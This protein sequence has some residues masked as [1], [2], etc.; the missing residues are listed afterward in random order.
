MLVDRKLYLVY[1][2][3][4]ILSGFL[5][6]VI[7][8]RVNHPAPSRTRQLSTVAPMVLRLKAWESRSSPN[9]VNYS[10]AV[11]L[12]DDAKNPAGMLAFSGRLILVGFPLSNCGKCFRFIDQLAS[13]ATSDL[14]MAILGKRGHGP[15]FDI[16]REQHRGIVLTFW[17]IQNAKFRG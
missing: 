3:W 2:P 13:T 15:S 8:A 10:Y 9:L 17:S 4:N 6:L 5:G 12:C 11:S 7:I 14:E 1:N 16:F